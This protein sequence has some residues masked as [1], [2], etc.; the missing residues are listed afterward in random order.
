MHL[1]NALVMYKPMRFARL[2]N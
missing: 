2:W 1:L